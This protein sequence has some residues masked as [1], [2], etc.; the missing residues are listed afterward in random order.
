MAVL[1]K[2]FMRMHSNDL[3]PFGCTHKRSAWIPAAASGSELCK[4]ED[5]SI[6]RSSHDVPHLLVCSPTSYNAGRS[7]CRLSL[8]HQAR[9]PYDCWLA[10]AFTIHAESA[11][12]LCG[13]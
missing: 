12:H 8:I 6:N 13:S 11:G 2:L 9:F 5:A 3:V 4:Q 1:V 7:R 10:T